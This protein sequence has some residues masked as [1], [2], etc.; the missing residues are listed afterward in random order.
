MSSEITKSVM[1]DATASVIFKALID[2]EELVQWMLRR[3]RMDASVGGEY[4]FN[5]YSAAKKSE[6]AARGRRSNS[7]PTESPSIPLHRAGIHRALRRLW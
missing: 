2:Q 7:S 6:T 3:A 5:F 4:E 1:I